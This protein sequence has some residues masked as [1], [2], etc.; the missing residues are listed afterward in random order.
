MKCARGS[1]GSLARSRS[2]SGTFLISSFT[3]VLLAPARTVE[4]HPPSSFGYTWTCLTGVGS[5]SQPGDCY[6]HKT[7]AYDTWYYIPPGDPEGFPHSKRAAANLGVGVWD[8]TNGHPFNFNYDNPDGFPVG[9]VGFQICGSSAPVG[10][11]YHAALANDHFSTTRIRIRNTTSNVSGIAAHEFGHAVGLGHSES[12][13]NVMGAPD[14]AN[15][16]SGDR[17]GRCQI[18]GHTGHGWG[19]SCTIRS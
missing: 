9:W 13:F 7:S 6:R 16:G 2:G 15:L 11:H 4:A 5:Q 19:S 10:C 12:N 17:E 8:Q 18:Y 3:I 14:Q 1:L